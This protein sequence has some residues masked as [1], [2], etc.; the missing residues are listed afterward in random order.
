MVRHLTGKVGFSGEKTTSEVSDFHH[1]LGQIVS[2]DK[3]AR[4]IAKDRGMVEVGNDSQN[5]LRPQEKSYELSDSEYHE[6]MGAGD[7]RG[8]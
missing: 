4:Q 3:H 2:S 1:G 6:V 8:N 5:N 7:I